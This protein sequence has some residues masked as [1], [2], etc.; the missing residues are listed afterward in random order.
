MTTINNNNW[1][2]IVGTFSSGS[3]RVYIDGQ[4]D[5]SATL[6]FTSVGAPTLNTR[7]GMFANGNA[8]YSGILDD[9]RIYSRALSA[10]EIKAIYDATK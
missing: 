1:H 4:L 8:P 9:V 10:A 7:I 2:L 6:A 3:A 5:N